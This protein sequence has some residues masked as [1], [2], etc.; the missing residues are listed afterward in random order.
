MIR[1]INVKSRLFSC[2]KAWD[3]ITINSRQLVS[4]CIYQCL[5]RPCDITSTSV[6]SPLS[7]DF[8]LRQSLVIFLLQVFYLLTLH[9]NV[10]KMSQR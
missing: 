10:W 2:C 9:H 8:N 4:S 3:D 6:D 1:Y 5:A 7:V